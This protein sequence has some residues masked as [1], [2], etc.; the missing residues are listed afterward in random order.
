[1]TVCQTRCLM[2]RIMTFSGF[3]EVPCTSFYKAKPHAATKESAD[4]LLEKIASGNTSDVGE[5]DDEDDVAQEIIDESITSGRENEENAHQ[6][7]LL[8]DRGPE[9]NVVK[10]FQWKK[11]RF[12]PPPNIDFSGHGDCLPEP[13]ETCTPHTYFSRYVPESIFKC[14]AEQTNLYSVQETH[15]NVNTTADEI[16]K[17][18]GIHILMGVIALP[19]VRLYW[20][21]I[22]KVPLI[23]ETM[24]EKRFFKLRNTLHIA[25]EAPGEQNDD[26]LWKV[27]PFLDQIRQR[28]LELAI[29]QESSIDEQMIPFKGQL[30]IKQYV[31]GKPT[32]WG[33]KVFALCGRS[34]LLYDFAVY[35]GE[36]T[37]PAELKK[38]YGL[39][40]GVVVHLSK[41]IPTGC[42]YQLYF[43]NYFTSVPLLRKLRNEKILAA[44]TV[45]SNRLG[46]CPLEPAKAMKKK[47]RGY[48][49]EYVTSDDIVV[50]SWKDNSS[51]CVA[52]NFVGIGNQQQVKRWDKAK[53]EHIF[54]EQ[55]EVITKYNRNMGGVDKMDFL[56]SLYRIKIKS[57]KWTLRALF[58]FVDIAV[59]NAWLEYIQDH[60]DMR[61]SRLLDLMHFRLQ[62]AEALITS[63]PSKRK[64]GRPS[65]EIEDAPMDPPHKKA[66]RI[67]RPCSD[68]RY[69]GVDHWPE[70]RDQAV[71]SR[72]KYER[73]RGRSRIF[74]K[75][76]RVPLCL[77]KD[78]NCFYRFH[79]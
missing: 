21:P 76:C 8:Q 51:V 11:R 6:T 48:S 17:L 29:E 5:S 72:C 44:G 23:S 45:R 47:T 24:S 19:R 41:R 52:S 56:L 77:T 22:M 43:D 10:N 65:Q 39:C 31:K 4:R 58:H 32:P 16:R 35:Q 37:I 75:K 26:R 67:Q 18:F 66:A 36:N 40:S 1:M 50:V 64:R 3:L 79:V 20:D 42:N 34:G 53:R 63:V 71:P 49:T 78:R 14:M 12:D 55:P 73:C 59:C 15:N 2:F 7:P 70:A 25:A 46:K 62:I 61:R 54:V 69:D 57:R 60:P 38:D 33:I 28:C 9:E 30:S 68:S 74:C 27:R 13:D